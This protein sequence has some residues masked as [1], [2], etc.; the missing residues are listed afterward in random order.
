M[1]KVW[2]DFNTRDIQSEGYWAV[3]YNKLPLTEQINALDLKIGEDVILDQ[4]EDDFEVTA[5]LD[6]QFVW[7]TGKEELVALPDWETL[8]RLPGG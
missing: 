1:L 7:G 3:F 2:C 8:I 5:R 4:D 6:R